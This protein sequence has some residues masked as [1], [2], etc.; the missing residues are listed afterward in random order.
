[1]FTKVILKNFRS[2]DNIIFDLSKK[3]NQAKNLAIVYGENGSGKSNLMSSFV[4][5]SELLK[6]MDV[7]DRYQELLNQASAYDD[8]NITKQLQKHILSNMR[9]IKAIIDD[10]RMVG[11]DE[12][13]SVQYEFCVDNSQGTYIIEMNSDEIIH[14][15][16]EYKLN[17]RRSLY[18]D[19][20]KESSYINTSIV[21][22]K[23]LLHDI[24]ADAKRFWGKH[25]LLS[26]ILH[27]IQDKSDTFGQKNLSQN[28]SEVLYEFRFISCSVGIGSR[29]WKELN[30]PILMLRYPIEGKIRRSKEK[31][32]DI[33]EN[34]FTKF[35]SAI[36]S[37]ILRLEY[38]RIYVDDYIEYRLQIVRMLADSYRTID[39]SKESRGNHQLLNMLCFL[40]TSCFGG[41]VILD[42][43]D[44]GIHDLLFKKILQEISPYI[45][46]QIIM[47]THNTML[48]ESI[49]DKDSI[50]ILTE[51]T[52]CHKY[53]QCIS[54]YDK[55]TYLAN[56][57]R[58][59]YLNNEYEGIPKVERIDFENLITYLADSLQ[60]I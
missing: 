3:G 44:S 46:G 50:Y 24:K 18:F 36:N 9:D 43:A 51:K 21:K 42:E 35:F 2:F 25:S 53:V 23:D 60:N 1:M 32:I 5:L 59:K 27:E 6:T 33:I 49:I 11:C 17:R 30:A 28:F 22:D 4:L 52:G 34:L 57:I 56:N 10:Y 15:R 20:S 7:R 13:I 8:E 29:E 37:D 58:N 16:L 54:D 55:R 19:Y 39:F 31:Q 41:V 47:S 12:P 14:E 40:I 45:S 26:I 38:K 48:M